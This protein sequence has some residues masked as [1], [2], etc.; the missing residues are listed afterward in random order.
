MNQTKPLDFQMI[1][2]L[3]YLEKKHSSPLKKISKKYKKQ[4]E[5]NAKN[6]K[7]KTSLIDDRTFQQLKDDDFISLAPKN[8]TSFIDDRTY[9]EVKDDDFIALES[10]EEVESDKEFKEITDVHK[11]QKQKQKIETINEVKKTAANKNKTITA[12]KILKKYKNMK[13]TK[14]T[15]LV[16]E[17]D[18]ETI[19]YSNQEDLFQKESIV[20]ATNKVLDFNEFE[21]QQEEAIKF[22]KL[23]SKKSIYKNKRSTLDEEE[24][25]IEIIKVP[26]KRK[27]KV[28]KASQIAAK[29]YQKS[30]KTLDLDN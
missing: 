12:N 1:Q 30:T 11:K 19:D 27:Q 17:E 28:D 9:Q 7:N 3:L 13:K 2:Q 15:Y 22:Y 4:R 10:H 14:K 25:L 16:N 5:A 21:K 24:Q 29:K 23:F 8:K 20:N 18:L 26:K 6:Q